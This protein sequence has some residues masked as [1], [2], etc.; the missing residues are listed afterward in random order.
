MSFNDSTSYQNN[1][2][3]IYTTPIEH[4][5][6][7]QVQSVVFENIKALTANFNSVSKMAQ[8]VGT[9][10]D[11]A[12]SRESIKNQINRAN[13]LI[14]ETRGHINKLYNLVGVGDPRKKN[15][16]KAIVDKWNQDFAKFTDN[17]THLAAVVKDKLEEI[18][19]STKSYGSSS[20]PFDNDD[21]VS[22]YQQQ[23]YQQQQLRQQ[24]F[25]RLESEREFQDSLIHDRDQE[26]RAIQA[27][28]LEI[29]EITKNVATLVDEQGEIVDDIHSNIT[30]ANANVVVAVHEVAEA[31]KLQEGV[32]NKLLW[33]AG[34]CCI[35]II[36][37]VVIVVVVLKLRGK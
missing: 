31:E 32:R 17:Y 11:N 8:E 27:Q 33:L 5:E 37:A 1:Q 22:A 35:M 20:N 12:T 14:K 3:A 10:S 28:M 16:R 4:D 23:Q 36:A 19:L 34:C 2:R 24:Q 9:Y 29:N 21:A 30:K 6:F 15:E 25:S 18:P 26:I 7:S 13:L